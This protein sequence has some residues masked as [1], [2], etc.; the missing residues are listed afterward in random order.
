MSVCSY[1]LYTTPFLTFS[2]QI[3]LVKLKQLIKLKKTQSVCTE[4]ERKR[5]REKKKTEREQC[6]SSFFLKKKNSRQKNSKMKIK[7]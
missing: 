1:N 2:S 5:E 7:K 6:F 3:T 4:K